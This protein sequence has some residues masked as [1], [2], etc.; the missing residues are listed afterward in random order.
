MV[1][2]VLR[3]ADEVADALNSGGPVVA[4][5]TTLVCHGFSQGRG[6]IAAQRA[7]QRVREAGAVPCTVGV[8]DGVVCAG[9]S[10]AELSRFAE[11]GATARK[12]GARDIAA[13]VAQRALGATTVGGTLAVCR[14]VGVRFLGTGGIGGVHRGFAESLDISSDLVALAHTPAM[15]VSSGAKAI[16]DVAATAELLETLSVP[17]LGWRTDT[18]P[19]FYRGG[20]GPPVAARVEAAGEAAR[21]AAMHWQLAGSS[22]LL[23]GRAPDPELDIDPVL[24]EA[25]DRVRQAGVTGQAVTPAVLA[26]VEE[27]TGGR[28][29][30]VNQQLIADNAALAAEVAVAY[31]AES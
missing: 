10:A 12:V 6:L 16:L 19:V 7:E 1:G 9:L 3:V 26:V 18:L 8:V 21:I 2:D 25:V 15:V 30:A 27:L 13:C 22:G 28:S 29:V 5:E 31:A 14:R 17:V 4:L 24:A 11:A 23:L 20:G